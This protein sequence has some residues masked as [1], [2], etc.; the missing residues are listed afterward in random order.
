MRKKITTWMLLCMVVLLSFGS[1]ASA[2]AEKKTVILGT[3]ADYMPYEF[4]KTIDG[5]DTIVGFDIEIAKEIAKDMGAELVIKDAS[6]D[7]LLP[8]LTSGRIDF[9]ISGMNPTEERRKS[10][11][12]SIPYYEAN[13][14]IIVRKG[15]ESKYNT[16]ESLEGARFGVQ[17]SSIQE[18]IAESIPNSNVVSLDKIPDLLLQLETERVDVVIAEY[19]IAK[20][21]M[22]EETMVITDAKPTSEND[23]YAVGVRKGNEE[24]LKSIN[25]TLERLIKDDQVQK[26]VDEAGDLAAGRVSEKE[27]LNT[28][29]FF[30]K[31]RDYYLKGIQYTLLIS[32]LGVLFGFLLG[33]VIALMRMSGNSIFKFIATAYIEIMRGTPMLVQLFLIHYSLPAFDIKFTPIQSGILALS[34]NSAAYLAEIF[35]AGIQGV[36]RGQLEAARSLGMT[37]KKAM[38]HIILPQALKGVLP[39]IGNEF[40]VI[41]KESSIVSF[42][43]VMDIMYQAQILRGSTFAALNPLLVA[44]VIYFIMTFVLSKL[45]GVLER[46][47]S[48]SD[49]R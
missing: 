43:G 48:A 28:F 47:L 30:W 19:P 18:R 41:I 38:R 14:A 8:E 42:I 49:N 7:A 44:A 9:V 29:E 17:K 27:Q 2:E 34:L 20:A 5:V 25:A 10:I 22:N 13:Q 37:K 15:E 45:L 31:Y 23:E 46:K 40:I 3:S 26:F 16:V 1:I 39:A 32:A 21:N 24:L 33:L 36:D 4:H 12:F 6:F 35:R 11:D